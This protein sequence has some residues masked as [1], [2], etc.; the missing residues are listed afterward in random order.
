MKSGNLNL[1]EPS[2]SLQAC[3]GTTLPLHKCK[4]RKSIACNIGTECYIATIVVLLQSSNPNKF[5]IGHKIYTQISA[6]LKTDIQWSFLK[7][8]RNAAN[9][10]EFVVSVHK[11]FLVLTG[12]CPHWPVSNKIINCSKIRTFVDV[13]QLVSNAQSTDYEFWTTL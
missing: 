7:N 2:G 11:L 9:Y 13:L 8:K 1:L 5:N 10:L 6:N 4:Y 3:N 12:R